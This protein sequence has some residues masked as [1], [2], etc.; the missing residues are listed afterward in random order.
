MSIAQVRETGAHS[1]PPLNIRTPHSPNQRKTP[2]RSRRWFRQMH[3][4]IGAIAALLLIVLALSG[5]LLNHPRLLGA[6]SEKTLSLTV[7]PLDPT[8]L[9]RGTPSGLYASYDSGQ[10]WAEVPMLFVAERA[11]DIAFVPGHP[12]RVY[13]VLEDLGL[14]RSL[15]NGIVW[16][17]VPLGFVPLAEGIRLQKIGIGA[18]E[19]LHLW[20]SGGLM[21]S[22]DRG[23]TW[24]SVGS[25]PPP[26]RDL[27]TLVH[28]IHTGY[29]FN[30]WFFYLYDAAAWILVVLTITGFLI[31]RRFHVPKHPS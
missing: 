1:G 18:D 13:V 26:G 17:R 15:D 11:V 19:S 9:F 27:Y 6:P 25:T 22:S 2:R 24:I 16:E 14:I 8:H 20:T 30:T 31:W 28:Q 21:R 4:Y 10:T 29:F 5:F 12:E 23:Q 7:N 3:R